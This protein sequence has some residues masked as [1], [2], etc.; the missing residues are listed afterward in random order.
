MPKGR[1]A[2]PLTGK[3]FG[4]L[5][6][7]SQASHPPGKSTRWLCLC[8]CGN[9]KIIDGSSLR[10]GMTKSCGCI[11]FEQPGPKAEDLTGKQFGRWT[12]LSQGEHGNT[13]GPK[14]NCKCQCGKEGTVFGTLLRKGHSKS[15]G[16]LHIERMKSRTGSSHPRWTGGRRAAEKKIRAEQRDSFCHICGD[17]KKLCWDHNHETGK[18]RG[19]LCDRCNRALGLFKDDADILMKATTYLKERN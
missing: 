10:T 9:T 3:Q 6:V 12:V 13:G 5:T 16:C 19:T 2:I 7:V 8:S 15:C 4:R 14:W 18:Y 1:I 11:R 17:K